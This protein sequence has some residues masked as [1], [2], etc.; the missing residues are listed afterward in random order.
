[1]LFKKNIEGGTITK[2]DMKEAVAQ[3]DSKGKVTSKIA[4]QMFDHPDFYAHRKTPKDIKV[5][6]ANLMY[7][8]TK[9]HDDGIKSN[10]LVSLHETFEPKGLFFSNNDQHLAVIG[11]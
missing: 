11:S 2:E 8:N 7:I 5:H 3:M 1:M 6:Q 9:F 4:R 10:Q